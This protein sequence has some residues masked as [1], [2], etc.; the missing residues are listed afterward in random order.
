MRFAATAAIA[1]AS[2]FGL[3]RETNCMGS[4]GR[5]LDGF[6]GRKSQ[7]TQSHDGP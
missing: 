3:G 6:L 5:F 1:V 7:C 4:T 2:T